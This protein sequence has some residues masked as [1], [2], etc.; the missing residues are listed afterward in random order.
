M[1]PLEH[2][3]LGYRDLNREQKISRKKRNAIP[4]Q[5]VIIKQTSGISQQQIETLKQPTITIE[6]IN[7]HL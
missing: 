4:N 1:Q 5:F 2:H 6:D 7:P 3:A